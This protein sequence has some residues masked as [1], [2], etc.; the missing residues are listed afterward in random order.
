MTAMPYTV[1]LLTEPGEVL[2]MRVGV[3]LEAL[4]E[5]PCGRILR[6]RAPTQDPR[7]W[8]A[9]GWAEPEEFEATY[10]E[11]FKEQAKRN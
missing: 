3:C 9:V 4:V 1:D 2:P 6:L 11:S 5:M 7:A 10:G 8:T